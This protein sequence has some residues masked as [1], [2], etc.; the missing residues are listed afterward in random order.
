MLL[1]IFLLMMMQSSDTA[2]NVTYAVNYVPN[3][4]TNPTKSYIMLLTLPLTVA[5]Y[6]NVVGNAT[7]DA[8]A[9]VDASVGW[10]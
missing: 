10:M 5:D 9:V 6:T 3:D 1:V 4:Y 2:N 8:D 7:N